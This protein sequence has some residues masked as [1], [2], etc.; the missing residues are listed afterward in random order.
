VLRIGRQYP[1]QIRLP[2]TGF[3]FPGAGEAVA[4]SRLLDNQEAVCVVNP[5]GV[6]ARGGDVVVAAELWPVGTTFTVVVNTAQA[7][8]GAGAFNGSHPV[9]STVPVKGLGHAD[10]PAF[11]EIRDVQPAEV[12]V[13]IKAF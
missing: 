12:L 7:A 2:G 4:W 6:A 9:G 8:A 1:R 13:L 5:N 11:I 3:A 10:E